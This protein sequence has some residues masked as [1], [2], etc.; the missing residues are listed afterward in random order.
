MINTDIFEEKKMF[1]APKQLV[2]ETL[3][4]RKLY[5]RGFNEVVNQTKT[6]EEIMRRSSLQ[7][8]IISILLKYLYM[9]TSEIDYEIFTNEIGLD[10]SQ[11]NNLSSDIVIF[12]ADDA[13]QY[14]FD[15]HY[16]HVAP[17][18]AFQVDVKIELGDTNVVEYLREKNKVLFDFGVER[19]VWIFTEDKKI[20][21]AQPNRVWLMSNWSKDTE[22]LEG[23]KINLQNMIDEKRY[24]N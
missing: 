15:G 6:I 9:H 18:I 14:Q 23:H 22:L 3:N 21:L 10:I 13:L 5:R 8:N 20:L 19:V 17:K 1:Y 12:D 16:F 24:Q 2:Y 4:A 11:D 7:S